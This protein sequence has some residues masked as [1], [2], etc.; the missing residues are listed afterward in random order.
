MT[1]LWDRLENMRRLLDT[2][3]ETLLKAG[4]PQM[5]DAMRLFAHSVALSNLGQLVGDANRAHA[6]LAFVLIHSP[7]AKSAE[8]LHGHA[9]GEFHPN[10]NEL[11]PDTQF[12]SPGS[13]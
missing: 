11:T 3:Q 10:T 5:N 13:N 2:T 4:Q 12:R 8:V 6:D 7:H 1:T 9:P